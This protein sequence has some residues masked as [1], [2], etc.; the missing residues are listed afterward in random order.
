[1]TYAIEELQPVRQKVSQ[2]LLIEGENMGGE[3]DL[4]DARQLT[5]TDEQFQEFCQHH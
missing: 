2:C 4:R 3:K 1:M 5:I